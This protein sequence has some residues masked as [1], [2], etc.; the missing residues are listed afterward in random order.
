MLY[1]VREGRIH[2]QAVEYSVAY[3]CNLRC[4]SCS[5]MSP[6]LRAQLPPI[7]SFAADVTRLATAMHARW[8]RLLGGEP[9][10]N[11]DLVAFAKVAKE[12][13]IADGVS[14]TTNGLLLPA[15]TDE[16]WESVD[17]VRVST[18]PG[19]SL[20]ASALR[21]VEARARE[22]GTAFEVSAVDTFRTTMV[23]E[24]HPPDRTTDMIFRTCKNAHLYH[25]HMIH[26]GR[27]FKC[28]C[29]AFLPEFLAKAGQG[30]YD[31]AG[32][33]FDIH[34]ATSLF[35]D[36]QAF[37]LETKTLAACRYCLGYV[38]KLQPHRQ[39][40]PEA[41]ANPGLQGTTRR[42]D[43]DRMKLVKASVRYYRRRITEAL[44]GRA[45]W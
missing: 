5:H 10:L 39:L 31:P 19:A 12:S 30:G 16:F 23:T 6:F 40:R 11:P 33:A 44:T 18:Y 2:T 7:D 43:L 9:L 24:P 38:G 27:L 45:Q 22:S 34:G 28:A 25:C 26:E 1:E 4:V 17:W 13:G 29:P 15:M 37:L 8:I 14:V 21:K 35:E 42:R 20:P 41:L 32:D 36:L 3:H